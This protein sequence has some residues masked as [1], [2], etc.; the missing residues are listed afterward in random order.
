[1]TEDDVTERDE[2]PAT[3]ELVILVGLQG[4]GKS[5]YYRS[6]LAATHALV[7]KDLMGRRPHRQRRQMAQLDALLARGRSVVVDNTNVTRADREPLIAL[8]HA[9]H[10]R[11]VGYYLDT[12]L[13]LCLERN[14][15][16]EGA[17]RVPLVAIYTARK[18][19]EP[20]DGAE[21]F[22]ALHRITPETAI[23][24][25]PRMPPFLAGGGG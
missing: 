13:A 10:A 15:R 7:S 6:H 25:A 14:A 18:R 19:L 5:T 11:A 21:G 16:R 17:A 23:S 9:Y 22:D 20:P 2:Q 24:D 3:L 12:P 4:A 8:A 1:M